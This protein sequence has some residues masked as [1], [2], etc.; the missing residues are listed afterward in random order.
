M[1]TTIHSKSALLQRSLET[2][3]RSACDLFVQVSD[4]ILDDA[5]RVGSD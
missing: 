3:S 1:A 4:L 2:A 5:V